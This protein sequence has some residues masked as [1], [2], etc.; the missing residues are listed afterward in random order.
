MPG[1]VGSLVGTLVLQGRLRLLAEESASGYHVKKS[2][3]KLGRMFHQPSE[4]AIL[5]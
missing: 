4:N 1:L 5:L 3:G 2:F